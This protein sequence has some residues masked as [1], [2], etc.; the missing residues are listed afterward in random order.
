M[1][2][3]SRL[4]RQKET[5]SCCQT[6]CGPSAT[7]GEEQHADRHI[8]AFCALDSMDWHCWQQTRAPGRSSHSM[9]TTLAILPEFFFVLSLA[10]GGEESS[11]EA[12]GNSIL[13][14]NH[15]LASSGPSATH[16]ENH[17]YFTTA[18]CRPADK[19]GC[20]M[21]AAVAWCRFVPRGTQY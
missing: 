19:I 1:A 14:S 2:M 4:R 21:C 8:M 7:N 15:G 20:C 16:G 12:E 6:N 3:K 18:C 9:C 13:L 11:Q 17:I 5:A 10:Y